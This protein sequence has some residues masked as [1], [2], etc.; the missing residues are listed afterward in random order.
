M[1]TSPHQLR[2]WLNNAN[3]S[4]RWLADKN[5]NTMT[6]YD[7]LAIELNMKRVIKLQKMLDATK[8]NL[9]LYNQ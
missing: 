4:L 7:H 9:Y 1:K 8:W 2:I 3:S 5:P 6:P